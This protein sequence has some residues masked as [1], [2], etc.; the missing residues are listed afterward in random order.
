MGHGFQKVLH[1]TKSLSSLFFLI[2]IYIILLSLNINNIIVL[3]TT[4]FY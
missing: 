3:T 2:Y 4:L 1:L